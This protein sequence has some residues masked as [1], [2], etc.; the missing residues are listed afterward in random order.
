MFE[1][2]LKAMRVR[3]MLPH[4]TLNCDFVT[5]T[6]VYLSFDPLVSKITKRTLKTEVACNSNVD[7]F[8]ARIAN[9]IS[10]FHC[11]GI[12]NQY[13]FVNKHMSFIIMIS[14][15]KFCISQII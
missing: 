5:I 1:T 14:Y 9:Q 12:N 13:L 3:V 6:L 11:I 10:D 2:N 15:G 7:T 4:L 8:G